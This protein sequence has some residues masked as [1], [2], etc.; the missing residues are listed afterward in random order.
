MTCAGSCLSPRKRDLDG[1]SAPAGAG[2]LVWT[3]HSL[4][5]DR[6]R[7]MARNQLVRRAFT[8][9]GLPNPQCSHHRAS[10]QGSFVRGLSMLLP[11]KRR[12]PAKIISL[13]VYSI[14]YHGHKRTNDPSRT[15]FHLYE[16][17]R[18]GVRA[19]T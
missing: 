11:A 9:V 8:A 4:L 15:T 6:G 3:Q 18:S 5:D 17:T 14:N 7:P 12:W 19:G 10:N 2:T 16:M 1:P 13:T